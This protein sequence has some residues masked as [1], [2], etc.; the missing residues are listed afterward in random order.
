MK[1]QLYQFIYLLVKIKRLPLSLH[2]RS[3]SLLAFAAR[4]MLFII[5]KELIPEIHGDGNERTAAYS[6]I[7]GLLA[8]IFL[9][10]TF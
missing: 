8:M 1:E 3:G 9:M 4:A 5:Y 10:E 2:Y 6:F 7:L